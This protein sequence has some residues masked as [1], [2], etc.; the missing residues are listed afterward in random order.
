MAY[1]TLTLE[2]ILA[3]PA[4]IRFPSKELVLGD[5]YEQV[6]AVGK[7]DSLTDYSITSDYLTPAESQSISGQFENWRGVQAFLFSPNPNWKPQKRYV[8]KQWEVNL[9]SYS[10]RQITATFEEVIA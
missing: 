1:P 6:G 4:T 3:T 7:K 9:V 10:V 8:C 2:T 5:G